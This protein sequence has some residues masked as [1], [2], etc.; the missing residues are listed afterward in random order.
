MVLDSN[1]NDCQMV[2]MNIGGST[3]TSRSWDIKITQY[4]CGDEDMGGKFSTKYSSVPNMCPGM[5]I[6]HNTSME[7]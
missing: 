1:G 5:L 6:R 4:A 3:T 2:N 7:K